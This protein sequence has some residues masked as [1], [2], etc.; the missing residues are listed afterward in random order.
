MDTTVAHPVI[1]LGFKK[2]RKRDEKSGWFPN[3]PQPPDRTCVAH[4]LS[5]L[6]PPLTLY[7]TP[8]SFPSLHSH[9]PPSATHSY[10]DVLRLPFLL[11]VAILL[12][13]VLLF[14]A[15]PLFLPLS[16]FSRLVGGIRGRFLGWIRNLLHL[17]RVLVGV[18]HNHP[19]ALLRDKTH[20][21]E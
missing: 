3:P 11:W 19:V 8:Y 1:S 6:K 9:H 15:L 20:R 12:I 5:C 13:K 4:S 18:Q 17:Q 16:L 2:K 14:L 10:R 7:F 21:D